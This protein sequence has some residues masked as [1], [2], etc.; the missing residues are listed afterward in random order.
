MEELLET[1]DGTD[2]VSGKGVASPL[3]F[4]HRL[5]HSRRAIFRYLIATMDESPSGDD[6][7]Q[8]ETPNLISSTTTVIVIIGG[9]TTKS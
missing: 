8:I 1:D 9:T 2:R 7:P 5:P 3:S 4:R 6:F